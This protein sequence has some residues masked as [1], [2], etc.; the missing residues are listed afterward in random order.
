[1]I[2]ALA[3]VLIG[4]GA[5]LAFLALRRSLRERKAKS[6]SIATPKSA[7]P[8]PSPQ[9]HEDIPESVRKSFMFW[10]GGLAGV[11]SAGVTHQLDV[12]KILRHVGKPPPSTFAETFYG[13]PMGSFAQGERFAV[14]LVLNSTLQKKLD[15]WQKKSA[16]KGK[17]SGWLIS[18]LLSMFAAGSGEFLSNPPVV[19]KNYQIAN[20]VPFLTA[21]TELWEQ[22][23]VPRFFNGVAMGVLRKSLANAIVL[24]SVGPTKLTL[25]N[26]FPAMLG[27]DGAQ[28]RTALAFIAG[29]MT[30]S[31][32]EVLT[33][34]PDQ[35]K[36]LTQTGMGFLDALIEATKHPFRGAF[37]AGIRKGI[38]RGIN[39]GGLALFVAFFERM[40]RASRTK[41]GT[42]DVEA[43]CPSIAQGA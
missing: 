1:M 33:N 5:V 41:K 7:L 17:R 21:C 2:A 32:A 3:S 12:L 24:Q 19:I 9:T 27:G 16:Y 38:I 42:V 35:V 28:T 39:W 36:T 6:A 23:G 26:L 13:A 10:G 43:R 37:W 18:F 14:T 29:S 25:I 34:H 11:I 31:L 30:G 15:N 8:V 4:C 40:Y 20:R 22:G